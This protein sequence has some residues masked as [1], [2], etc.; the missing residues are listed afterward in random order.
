MQPACGRGGVLPLGGRALHA[1]HHFEGGE[2]DPAFRTKL[3]IASGLVERSVAMGVP[4]RAVVA[5]LFYGEDRGFKRS[6]EGLG[7]AYVLSLKKSHSWWYASGTIGALWKAALEAGW[8]GAEEPG[9]WMKVLRRFR[10]G[11]SEE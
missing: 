1:S 11:H 8:E 10:D 7:V 6:L 4:F 3:E 9:E 5:D 2:A